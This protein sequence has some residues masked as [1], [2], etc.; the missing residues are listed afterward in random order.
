MH[1]S[2]YIKSHE[3]KERAMAA[4]MRAGYRCQVCNSGNDLEVHHRTYENLGHELPG[5]LT[6]LCHQCHELYSQSLP[7]D[8]Y[9][10]LS[11][12]GWSLEAQA[13]D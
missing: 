12:L 6:V 4:I 8:P 2:E 1:Y 11:L 13:H 10:Y 3:W 9:N 5:D 7:R